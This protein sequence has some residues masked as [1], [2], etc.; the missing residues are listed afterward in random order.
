MSYSALYA[1]TREID[2]I[3]I[4]FHRKRKEGTIKCKIV[5]FLHFVIRASIIERE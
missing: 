2:S 3:D 5:N 1:G 4:P